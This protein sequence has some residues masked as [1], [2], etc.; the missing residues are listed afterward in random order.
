MRRNP[1]R[2]APLGPERPK[3]FRLARTYQNKAF[4]YRKTQKNSKTSFLLT[5]T[6]PCR[7]QQSAAAKQPTR[8]AFGRRVRARAASP[9]ADL[10]TGC[11][12]LSSSHNPG[13]GVAV[14]GRESLAV[15][16][17]RGG[18]GGPATAILW[19]ARGRS[20]DLRSCGV[21]FVFSSSTKPW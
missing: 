11:S 10:F 3:Y 5:Q 2:T 4:K 17:N 13:G 1:K 12:S 21:G 18:G 9:G 14:G 15:W 20:D 8:R 16:K 6:E 7:R 19:A